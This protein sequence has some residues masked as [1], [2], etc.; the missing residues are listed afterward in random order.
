MVRVSLDAFAKGQS[1]EGPLLAQQDRAV[2]GYYN[3][4]LNGLIAVMRDD[5]R[6]ISAATHLLFVAKT[7]E[8]IGDN[9]AKIGRSLDLVEAAREPSEPWAA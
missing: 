5:P 2:D 8:R 3:C 9:A 4:L 6:Q 1:G 7:L